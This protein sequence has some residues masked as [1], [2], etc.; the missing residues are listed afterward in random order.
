MFV[1]TLPV[2]AGDYWLPHEK[3]EDEKHWL[4][5]PGWT[6]HRTGPAALIL[7]IGGKPS[8]LLVEELA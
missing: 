6:K 5:K 7:G 8:C 2:R 1:Y 4:N 3:S